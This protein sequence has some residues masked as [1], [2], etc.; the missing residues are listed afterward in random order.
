M[1][2]HLPH[3]VTTL[4][5]RELGVIMPKSS[6]RYRE[7]SSQVDA[8]QRYS[9][10]DAFNLLPQLTKAKFDETVD[11]AIR[12]G[13][14]PRKADQ[15]VRGACE[16]PHGTG[17]VVRVLVFA[18]GEAA[19]LATSA[20]ADF[21]GTDE[22]IQKIQKENWLDFDKVVATRSMMPKLGRV[23]RVL[24]PRGLMP[25]PKVGTVVEADKMSETIRAL[26]AGKIDFRAEKNG[27]IIH[28]VI[29]KVSMGS[30]KLKDNFYALIA[31]LI[32]LKPVTAKGVYFRSI[33]ISSTMG[34]GIKIDTVDA[35]R[36]SERS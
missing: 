29:G 27:G 32:R 28:T 23:A 16:L 11:V 12:L 10:E 1:V 36:N 18:D 20:G 9:T 21:V 6:K 31:A 19:Q 26:K 24:G 7:I 34:P 35:H 3:P 4:Y 15:M 17:R 2:V 25:N 8:A 30:D 14:D 5:Y 33:T 13:V 22:F